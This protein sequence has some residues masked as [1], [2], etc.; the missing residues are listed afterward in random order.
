MG[1]EFSRN[2]SNIKV[3]AALIETID[4]WLVDASEHKV[5]P[6]HVLF[7]IEMLT[8]QPQFI[9]QND[10]PKLFAYQMQYFDLS[11]GA[12]VSEDARLDSGHYE[13]LQRVYTENMSLQQELAGKTNHRTSTNPLCYM[14]RLRQYLLSK[15]IMMES[16]NDKITFM[17]HIVLSVLALMASIAALVVAAIKQGP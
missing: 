13:S 10:R 1:S 9:V 6:P 12:I 4:R 11:N 3:C 17:A 8:K 2:V 5:I 14:I 7:E 15:R 16:T